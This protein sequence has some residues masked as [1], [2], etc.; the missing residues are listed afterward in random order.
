MPQLSSVPIG[1]YLCICKCRSQS[2]DFQIY[3]YVCTYHSSAVVSLE[4]FYSSEYN[5]ILKTRDAICSVVN[6]YNAGVVTHHNQNSSLGVKFDPYGKCPPFSSPIGVNTLLFR[7]MEGRRT[8]VYHKRSTFPL[9]KG[10]IHPWGKSW[11]YH[12]QHF[13]GANT[14][15]RRNASVTRDIPLQT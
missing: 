9:D 11:P 5:F 4:R 6:F 3:N 12:C 1:M 8:S 13:S 15:L 7:R 10:Q 14:R 2:Y